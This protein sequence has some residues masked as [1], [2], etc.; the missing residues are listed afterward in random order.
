MTDNITINKDLQNIIYKM[1]FNI[2]NRITPQ[3]ELSKISQNDVD[4]S[5][6]NLMAVINTE[7]SF[8]YLVEQDGYFMRNLVN[9]ISE[10]MKDVLEDKKI[11][12][13]DV[14]VIIKMIQQITVSINNIHDKRAA[15]V[16]ITRYSLVPLIQTIILL[17]AQMILSPIEYEIARSII[18]SSFLL[19]ETNFGPIT[20]PKN[21]FCMPINK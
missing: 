19:I 5:L 10:G 12:I 13:M 9:V 2:F 15:I 14:P 7:N 4:Y 21:W 6:N 8:K 3:E 16:Q 20:Y 11:N 18:T 1:A 17:V